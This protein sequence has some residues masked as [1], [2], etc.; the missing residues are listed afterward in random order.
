MASVV[1]GPAERRT[2]PQDDPELRAAAQLTLQARQALL[3]DS[4]EPLRGR[5]A[6]RSRARSTPPALLRDALIQSGVNARV[7]QTLAGHHSASFTEEAGEKVSTVLREASGSILVAAPKQAEVRS[8]KMIEISSAP[9]E[10]ARGLRPLVPRRLVELR[11]P[12]AASGV[13]SRLTAR[14][15]PRTPYCFRASR[16]RRDSNSRPSGSKPDALSN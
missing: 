4:H 13:R 10:I 12:A 2:W 7:A 15:S 11:P 14:N 6:L 5:G 3:V 8:A 16:A 9:G 1:A